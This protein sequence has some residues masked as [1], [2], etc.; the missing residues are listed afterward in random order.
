M[1]QIVSTFLFVTVVSGTIIVVSSE[2][3]FIIWVG[4]E[5][6]TLALVPILCSG[7]SPRNVEADNKYFLVQAS[8]AALLLNG[9]L[10]QAW[11]TGS[12]SILDPVNEVTSI[13]LSIA[14]AFK[15]GLAPVHFWFPDVLQGLPFFQ[16]LII[17]TW[18]KIA[19]LI[20]MFYFSQLGFSYLLITPSLI[21]VLI[22][23]W[24]G[25]NQTQVRKILAFS[26]I[27][28]MGWLVITSAYS[29]NAAIIMLVIYLIINTSL[30]LLFDHLKVS[31]LGHLNTISQL[32]PI[33]VALVL[34]VMLSL[35][36]LPPLT[37]FILKFTSL[38]F[39]VANNFIILSSIMII[40]N[41]QDYFFYLRI[42]FNTSLFLFPQH[43]ISSASWRNS[44]IISPLAPK[45]WL[46][47]VS[48]VLSTLAIPLTL[49]LYIIT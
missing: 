8:S 1:R 34:L 11:L 12:W 27:G 23:G 21:S 2:N 15:I 20:L 13:C 24:G 38:Y 45:A 42:S 35:G 40:G 37:G 22:G 26:S 30:F 6:S 33:S 48:T 19:P 44:T 10:G 31:T 46:S 43:I 47:S 36:G 25:L 7:F 4:L 32:S 39:L 17:A 29:F 3:W 28:N 9:A 14:L 41:L 18:Q 49:P 5:L 16:G